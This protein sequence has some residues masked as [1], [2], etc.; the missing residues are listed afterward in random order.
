MKT[1]LEHSETAELNLEV[2]AKLGLVED[3]EQAKEIFACEVEALEPIRRVLAEEKN[4]NSEIVIAP[5]LGRVGLNWLGRQYEVSPLGGLTS[6]REVNVWPGVAEHN[7]SYLLNDGQIKEYEGRVVPLSVDNSFDEE[8]LYL[9]NKSIEQQTAVVLD[10]KIKSQF[11]LE[12]ERLSFLS[13]QGYMILNSML[14]ETGKKPMDS[15]STMT[16][17]PL[18]AGPVVDGNQTAPRAYTRGNTFFIQGSHGADH[19]IGVR[20]QISPSRD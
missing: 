11:A 2:H 6:Q 8:G 19:S 5:L 12:S 3:Y 1:S 14:L 7:P 16:R 20:Y 9:T 18:L 13:I 10:T 15:G 17:F 4:I